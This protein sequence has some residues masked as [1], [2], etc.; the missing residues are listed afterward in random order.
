MFDERMRS[1]K[2][3][4]INPLARLFLAIPPWGLSVA[5]LVMGVITAVF[6]TQQQYLLGL[7]FWGLNRLF[8]G[9]DG[10]VARLSGQTSDFGGY[11]DII[12][13]FIV[14]A[15]T[16]I[17]LVLG[18]GGG[19]GDMLILA[20]IFL[21]TTYYVN[22]ASW[23]Y[24]AAILEKRNQ[25]N[26]D[27]LTSITMPAGLVGGTETIIFYTAFILFPSY[28]V[29]LFGLMGLLIVVTIG[30]RLVWAERHLD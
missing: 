5:G 19:D 30:Q 13:D 29:F 17:A 28:L 27:R 24:L 2:D 9:L 11:L 20:L 18:R 23:M 21:L 8:D 14:Y 15:I 12:F 16:P 22:S 6:L 10:A 1:F 26:A 3:T 4:A 7:L 25:G